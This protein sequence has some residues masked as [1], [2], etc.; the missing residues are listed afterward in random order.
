[1]LFRR[2][3]VVWPLIGSGCV[4]TMQSS[5]ASDQK[6]FT[7]SLLLRRFLLFVD[8]SS[9]AGSPLFVALV[10]PSGILGFSSK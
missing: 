8:V 3:I 6:C 9:N 1:M 2:A 10:I 7:Y 5:F 4:T